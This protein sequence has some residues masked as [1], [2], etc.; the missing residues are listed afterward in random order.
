MGMPYNADGLGAGV[1]KHADSPWFP[2]DSVVVEGNT[3]TYTSSH[4]HDLRNVF[5]FRR[6]PTSGVVYIDKWAT[7]MTQATAGSRPMAGQIGETVEFTTEWGPA[8]WTRI[9]PSSMARG[10]ASDALGVASNLLGLGGLGSDFLRQMPIVVE[11]SDVGA[12]PG[13]QQVVQKQPTRQSEGVADNFDEERRAMQAEMARLNA[14]L[15]Q[16]KRLRAVAENA[17]KRSDVARLQAATAQAKCQQNDAELRAE[18]AA[19]PAAMP[20]PSTATTA[21]YPATAAAVSP[22]MSEPEP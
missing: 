19:A 16:A 20:Y 17:A 5:E 7:G 15:D 8:R 1:Y 3:Y 11:T 22:F 12:P 9:T 4:S 2:F 10:L 18:F 13:Y 14:E 21:V 6:H